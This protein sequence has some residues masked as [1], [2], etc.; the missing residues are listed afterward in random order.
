MSSDSLGCFIYGFK[1]EDKDRGIIADFEAW[2]NDIFHGVQNRSL[3]SVPF[4]STI[5]RHH[6]QLYVWAKKLA[7]ED[8]GVGR[9]WLDTG[10]VGGREVW[11]AGW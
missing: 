3:C 5:K 6:L 10:E 1:W 8:H 2:V 7:L 11:K 9:E 4:L